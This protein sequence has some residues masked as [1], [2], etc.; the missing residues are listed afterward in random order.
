M[1]PPIPFSAAWRLQL[2]IQISNQTL[3]REEKGFTED[4]NRRWLLLC[5]KLTYNNNGGRLEPSYNLIR[6]TD[7]QP[8]TN[9]RGVCR[10]WKQEMPFTTWSKGA[11]S[12]SAVY[13]KPHALNNTDTF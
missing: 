10:A 11:V 2:D 9:S 6:M 1:K 3:P 13:G 12:T 4:R 5:R 8:L 7:H